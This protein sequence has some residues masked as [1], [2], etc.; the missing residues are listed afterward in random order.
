MFYHMKISL[1]DFL[2]WFEIIFMPQQKVEFMNYDHVI[3]SFGCLTVSFPDQMKE[4]YC[5]VAGMG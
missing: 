5:F 2:V 4:L 1:V 3:Y